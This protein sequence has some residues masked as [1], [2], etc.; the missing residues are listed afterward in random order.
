MQAL[1]I[2]GFEIL[3]NSIKTETIKAKQ[4][5]LESSEQENFQKEV[6][7]EGQKPVSTC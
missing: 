4:K 1:E 3:H 5:Q 6:P 7:N 2:N